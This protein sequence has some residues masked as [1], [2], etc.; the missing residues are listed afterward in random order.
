MGLDFQPLAS[1][2]HFLGYDTEFGGVAIA[3]AA[4]QNVGWCSI[5]MLQTKAET[6]A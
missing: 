3:A 2:V 5:V 6:H 1:F 4:L